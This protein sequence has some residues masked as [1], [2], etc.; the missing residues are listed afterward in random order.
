[1]NDHELKEKI[2]FLINESISSQANSEKLA[3]CLKHLLREAKS[4]GMNREEAY[5][6]LHSAYLDLRN[7]IPEVI[8]DTLLSYLDIITFWCHPSCYIW[9]KDDEEHE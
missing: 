4:N 2:I 3:N 7:K 8:D 1:M 6:V 9:S 5:Q